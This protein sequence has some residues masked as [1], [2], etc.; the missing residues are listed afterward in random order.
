AGGEQD[1][2]LSSWRHILGLGAVNIAQPDILY[3]G[4]LTRALRVAAMA[5]DHGLSVVPHS[6]NLTLVTVFTVHFMAAIDYAGPHVEYSI[7]PDT[8]FPW[9]RGIFDPELTVEDGVVQIPD[10][11]GWC[12]DIRTD[13]L[14]HAER[15]VSEV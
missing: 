2:L 9:Q 7:Y 4:G 11:P 6:A 5:G 13:W 10:G 1:C 8:Y 12:V 3:V 14:D 15:T